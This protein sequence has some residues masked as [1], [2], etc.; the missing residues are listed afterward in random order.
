[1]M[2]KRRY[3]KKTPSDKAK[4][5][6]KQGRGR[7]SPYD[8]ERHPTLA[9]ALARADMIDT[10]IAHALGISVRTLGT[11]KQNHPE[12]M[13]SLKGGKLDVDCRVA[14]ALCKRALGYSHPAIKV[15]M[16]DGVPVKIHFTK[17]YP[18]DT[19]SC[20]FWL[21]NRQPDLWRA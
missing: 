20:I 8:P 21:K 12:F 17:H 14:A 15:G 3:R 4:G 10:Q 2:K 11:W 9:Y 16:V 7:P 6:T 19:L 5:K 18:P 1:M 13:Q